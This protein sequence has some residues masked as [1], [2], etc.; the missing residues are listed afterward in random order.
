MLGTW[1]VSPTTTFC[2]RAMFLASRSARVDLRPVQL[3]GDDEH[4]SLDLGK[5]LHGGRIRRAFFAQSGLVLQGDQVHLPNEVPHGGVH[6]LRSA[7]GSIDPDPDLE[8]GHPLQ[9]SGL[10]GLD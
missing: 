1:A 6:P 8:L 7:V 4:G 5:P 10:V 9:V 3:A 2:T